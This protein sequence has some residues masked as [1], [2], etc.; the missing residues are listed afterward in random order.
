[1]NTDMITHSW[2]CWKDCILRFW[3]ATKWSKMLRNESRIVKWYVSGLQPNILLRKHRRYFLCLSPSLKC[4]EVL[5]WNLV[6][7]FFSRENMSPHNDPKD[8]ERSNCAC[9][10][11]IALITLSHQQKSSI[12][13][14]WR[15][16]VLSTKNSGKRG[17]LNFTRV[18]V[19][20]NRVFFG[21][22]MI[23]MEFLGMT[24]AHQGAS[25]FVSFFNSFKYLGHH[26]KCDEMCVFWRHYPINIVSSGSQGLLEKNLPNHIQPVGLKHVRCLTFAGR[27]WRCCRFLAWDLAA[28]RLQ[29]ILNM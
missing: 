28:T 4:S 11:R 3:A 18:L 26:Q 29:G 16:K 17:L 19:F 23:C 14:F 2:W 9:G 7:F 5:K 20:G 27:C 6:V 10:K 13:S 8:M 22:L 1:M 21:A 24:R 12:Y 25:W 15:E